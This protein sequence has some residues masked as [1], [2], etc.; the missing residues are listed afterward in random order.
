MSG[1][2]WIKV[3][4][5][6]FDDE[7][8]RLIEQL[9]EADSVLVI[10]VKL[11]A[12]AGQKNANGEIFIN[13]EMPYTDEMLSTIFHRKLNTVRL[14]LKTFQKFRMIDIAEDQT[15][16][17]CNWAKHQNVEGLDKIRQQNLKRQRRQREKRIEQRNERLL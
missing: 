12:L 7:K 5:D 10:W 15:I 14:A 9:P 13:D 17:I 11:L 4:T 16:V 2:S 6:M 1:V 3:R 8:I